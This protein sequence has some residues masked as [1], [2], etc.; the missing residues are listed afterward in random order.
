MH[1]LN[2]N[3]ESPVLLRCG[4]VRCSNTLQHYSS[5]NAADQLL[6]HILPPP[7]WRSCACNQQVVQ[8]AAFANLGLPV[9]MH[10]SAAVQHCCTKG[11]TYTLCTKYINNSRN[12]AC[13]TY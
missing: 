1:L 6:Y 3:P 11:N 12:T 13:A 2:A 7:S 4:V 8:A 10:H 5:T 9:L